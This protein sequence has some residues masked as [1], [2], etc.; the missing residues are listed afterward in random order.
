MPYLGCCH[1]GYRLSVLRLT[2][3]REH[4]RTSQSR[5]VAHEPAAGDRLDLLGKLDAKQVEAVSIEIAKLGVISAEEQ[6]DVI[7]EFAECNP[8][9]MGV[10][11]G[12]LDLAKQLVEKALGKKAGDTL[13]NMQ[14][15]IEALP[16]GFLKSVDSQNLLT[17][18]IDEHPQ[19]IA[20]ILSHLSAAKGAEILAGL[21]SDRQLSVIRRVAHH[22]PDHP[23]DHSRGRT[24]PRKPH[25]PRDEPIV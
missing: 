5:R 15:Q 16:F 14:Q 13:D 2:D 25:G 20:L 24:G 6:S 22:G 9:A 3:R 17:F 11:S 23:R 18:I 4:P 8:A 21:P 12:G 19:T 7:H 10:E 1:T